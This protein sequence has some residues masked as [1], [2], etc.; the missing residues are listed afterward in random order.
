MKIAS[1]DR[2][3]ASTKFVSLVARGFEH[4]GCKGE[5]AFAT[6]RRGVSSK[7]MNGLENGCRLGKDT[8]AVIIVAR[9]I[10]PKGGSYD[11][12]VN[13]EYRVP[14]AGYELAFPAGLIDTGETPE[15]AARRELAEETPYE[16][17]EI[18]AV[19]PPLASS[20]GITDEM[21]HIVR[22]F[23]VPKAIPGTAMEPAEDIETFLAK[24]TS[25]PRVPKGEGI[26]WSVRTWLELDEARIR[27]S[28]AYA[29]GG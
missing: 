1:L 26:V 3:L 14:L 2:V 29:P 16:V 20:S 15:D 11:Y 6:R 9:V 25:D 24:D 19:S 21:V 13:K 12:I 22:C 27:N 5:W 10:S 18:T 7:N 23:A 4:N 28:G 17:R 8:R